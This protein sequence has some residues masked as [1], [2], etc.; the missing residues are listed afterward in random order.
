MSFKLDIGK[1]VV[2]LIFIEVCEQLDQKLFHPTIAIWYLMVYIH[3]IYIESRQNVRE[4]IDYRAILVPR[5]FDVFVELLVPSPI[6]NRPRIDLGQLEQDASNQ[7][8]D[9]G[10][11]PYKL[12][13]ENQLEQ[14]K[15]ITVSAIAI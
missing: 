8:I 5:G 11:S 4:L 14:K 2:Y 12:N 13:E 15:S 10:L 6:S 9:H 3:K 1:L 7:P